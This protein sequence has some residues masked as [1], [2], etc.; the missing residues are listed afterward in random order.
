MTFISWAAWV[1][2]GR[3]EIGKRLAVLV[4]RIAAVGLAGNDRIADLAANAGLIDQ[5]ERHLVINQMI[6]LR[7]RLG[8]AFGV[9]RAP[10]AEAV[11]RAVAGLGLHGLLLRSCAAFR[12]RGA[13]QALAR[14]ASAAV[15]RY[16]T[17][18]MSSSK[19]AIRVR[20]ARERLRAKGLRPVQIW[21]P[22][23]RAPGFAEELAR[24]CRG[25]AAWASSPEGRT[26]LA[27]WDRVAA[28]AWASLD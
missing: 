4:E 26:E 1:R 15:Y 17:L 27:F 12:W 13:R 24:R 7:A 23:V 11:K 9:E 16:M 10:I 14:L 6:E 5:N 19:N 2:D 3:L 18:I 25:E 20:R 21:V 22:D 8:P 28:E